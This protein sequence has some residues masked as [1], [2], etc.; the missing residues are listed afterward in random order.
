MERPSQ[1]KVR[2][3]HLAFI[4][5]LSIKVATDASDFGWGG[6]TL[7]ETSFIS[8]EHFAIWESIQSSTYR[9]LLGVS[10]CLQSLVVQC[11]GEFVVLQTYAL[12]L[13]GIINRGSS[14]LSLNVLAKELF[15]FWLEYKNIVKIEWVS[16][17]K[18]M[19][20]QMRFP[21]G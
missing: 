3:G 4:V 2:F 1:P 18:K 17:E 20:S 7:D 11:E 21:N 19:P 16:R 5:G 13:L 10:R 8:H 14:K 9:E 15:W 12:N 6:H